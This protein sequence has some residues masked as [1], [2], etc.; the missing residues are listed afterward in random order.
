M[1]KRR[2]KCTACNKGLLE[3]ITSD[4]VTYVKDG[5]DKI[6]VIVKNLKH[7]KCPVCNEEYLDSKALDRVQ[8]EKYRALNLLTPDQLKTLR[9]NLNLTQTDMAGLLGVGEKSYFRW[10]NGLSIQSRSIDKYIKLVYENPANVRHL[11]EL[12]EQP[13]TKDYEKDNL[14]KYFDSLVS[15]ES[16]ESDL[17]G[18]V[19]HGATIS[20]EA[21]RKIEEIIKEYLD[22]E[23]NG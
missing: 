10:E 12:Q 23:K 13:K 1:E 9:K 15:I 7:E 3:N 5:S 14:E 11:K 8:E 16:E 21:K 4:Y 19:A 22:K 18:Q 20:E 6:K 17:I 2:I